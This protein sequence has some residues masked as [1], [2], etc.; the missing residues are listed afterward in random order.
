MKSGREYTKLVGKIPFS[1]AWK[2][3]IIAVVDGKKF[4]RK[5]SNYVDIFLRALEGS[6]EASEG[7][8]RASQSLRKGY[9]NKSK[10]Y[11][12]NHKTEIKAKRV[13]KPLSEGYK[14]RLRN[15]GLIRIMAPYH[16]LVLGVER[17]DTAFKSREELSQVADKLRGFK[18]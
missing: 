6:T 4:L 12:Q 11:Y 13:K 15:I 14:E 17:Y 3:E 2:D 9:Q 1:Q 7:L 5:K 8:A 16:R 18:G 10:K